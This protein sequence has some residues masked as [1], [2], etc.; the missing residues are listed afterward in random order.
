MS[1]PTTPNKALF[2]PA[3]GADVD[4]WDVPLNS[5]MAN[6]DSAFGGSVTLNATG[7]SGT[8]AL[9]AAQCVP[10]TI[11][12]SGTPTGTIT[13]TAPSGIGGEWVVSNNT[14]GGETVGFASAA[15]GSTVIIP[16]ASNLQVSCDGTSR[17]MVI[18]HTVAVAAGTDTQVQY[19]DAGLL[20][21]SANLIFDG[22]TLSTSGLTVA[23]NAS[24]T[25]NTTLGDTSGDALTV[26]ATPT[27]QTPSTFNGLIS[28]SSGGV[29]FPDNKTI[30]SGYQGQTLQLLTASLSSNSLYSGTYLTGTGAAFT[31]AGGTA[32]MSQA[33]TPLS[34][35][36][37]IEVNAEI[38]GFSYSAPGTFV[39]ALFNGTTLVD[40]SVQYCA[41]GFAI[42]QVLSLTTKFAS[43]GA[44]SPITLSLRI[45]SNDGTSWSLNSANNGGTTPQA[46]AVS[47][48]WVKEIHPG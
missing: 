21:G 8:Q 23:G 39:L 1:D 9:T 40:Y 7:L 13:Y 44:G 31:T 4:S 47:Y 26:N 5:N 37:T 45:G 22:T 12:L 32:L 30:S 43:P 25:G 48:L 24:V 34:S 36:S 2:V 33:I 17:G 29:K 46:G 20:A 16:A 35:S 10:A 28:V 27:F 3:H 41:N 6:I 18:N 38:K 14:S 42:A 15:G 19:N 11:I